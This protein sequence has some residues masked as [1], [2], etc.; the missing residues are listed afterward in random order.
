MENNFKEN[1]IYLRKRNGITQEELA[2]GLGM[3]GHTTIQSYECGRA[4]P[5]LEKLNALTEYFDVTLQ[6]LVY[7]KLCDGFVFELNKAHVMRSA[8]EAVENEIDSFIDATDNQMLIK[9]HK[10]DLD[11]VRRHKKHFA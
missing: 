6:E 9:A 4:F 3:K 11:I 8:F 10:V 2:H 5:R 1:L 7:E